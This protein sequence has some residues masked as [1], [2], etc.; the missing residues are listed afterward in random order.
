M[1]LPASPLTEFLESSMSSRLIQKLS[2]QQAGLGAPVVSGTYA[3]SPNN[4]HNGISGVEGMG[5]GAIAMSS[6]AS[7]GRGSADATG[8]MLLLRAPSVGA[9]HSGKDGV[10]EDGG[11]GANSSDSRGVASFTLSSSSHASPYVRMAVAVQQLDLG[12]RCKS[13]F[14]FPCTRCVCLALA[15]SISVPL[16]PFPIMAL[17]CDGLYF[18]SHKHSGTN[19]LE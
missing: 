6:A 4:A 14:A 16:W 13:V 11:D 3:Y 1:Y 12:G 7:G 19:I 5:V 2:G 15:M 17:S 10:R 18:S 9:G 8:T